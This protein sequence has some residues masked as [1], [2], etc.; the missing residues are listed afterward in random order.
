VQKNDDKLYK[1]K[2]EISEQ[3]KNA[4]LILK[5]I[6]SKLS[7]YKEFIGHYNKEIDYKRLKLISSPVVVLPVFIIIDK[8]TKR[9]ETK[10]ENYDD[11]EYKE[12]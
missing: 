12:Q 5:S 7:I 1:Q 6:E 9:R 11:K 8:N 10:D 2:E 3:F 4:T